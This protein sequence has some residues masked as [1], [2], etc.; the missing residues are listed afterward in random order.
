MFGAKNLL[1]GNKIRNFQLKEI[2]ES[3]MQEYISITLL[4]VQIMCDLCHLP[5]DIFAKKDY[6]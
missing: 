3:N 4:R 1:E 2:P 5:V 6:K